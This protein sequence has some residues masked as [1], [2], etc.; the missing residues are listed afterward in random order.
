M[1]HSGSYTCSLPLVLDHQ[2]VFCF[3]TC[4]LSSILEF[5]FYLFL[6]LSLLQIDSVFLSLFAFLSDK[7]RLLIDENCWTL[8]KPMASLSTC[9]L[10]LVVWDGNLVK[11]VCTMMTSAM[12]LAKSRF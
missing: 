1:V 12:S 3:R 4:S 8:D 7:G 10:E 2:L 9:H 11:C 5:S 6:V